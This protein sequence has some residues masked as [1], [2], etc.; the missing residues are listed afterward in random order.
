MELLLLALNPRV[1]EASA[2]SAVATVSMA[3]QSS[4]DPQLGDFNPK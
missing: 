2:S 4:G 3:S 1:N